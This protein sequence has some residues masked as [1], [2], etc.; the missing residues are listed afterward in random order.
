MADPTFAEAITIQTQ[1]EIRTESLATAASM[2]DVD[3]QGWDDH[4]PQRAIFEIDAFALSQEQKIRRA[5][6]YAGFISTAAIAGEDF[7]DQ[8]ITWFD[9][10]NGYGGKGRIPA[11]YAVWSLF[12]TDSANAGPFTIG[13]DTHELVAQANDGT[14]FQ[15]TNTSPVNIAKGGGALIEFT[16]MT[17]GSLAG[18]QNSGNI[19]HLVTSQ[20]GLNTIT[21]ASP[22]TLDEAARDIETT[23]AALVR[24]LGKWG[25]VGAG[26]TR[27]SFDYLIPTAA[28]TV[29]RWRVRD[30]NPN[31]PGTIE[32]IASNEGGASTSGENAAILAALG[33]PAVM[34]LGTGGLSV[35]SA[36]PLSVTVSGV[37]YGDGTNG[38]LLT[39]AKAALDVIRMKFPIGGDS[40]GYLRLDLLTTILMGGAFPASAPLVITDANG[41]KTVIILPGF[42]GAKHVVLTAPLVD[43]VVSTSEVV[44]FVYTGLVLG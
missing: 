36:T 11:T 31:G 4:S 17:I 8:A 32:V 9:I 15:S 44:T 42:K 34:T 23:S 38:S 39:N 22:A 19:T 14:L 24:A 5:L 2:F 10:D 40:D 27:T 25:T 16:C 37:L 1:A 21:N 29:T 12:V 33:A 3:V 18:N 41:Q 6:A 26:W 7:F 28:P 13:A 35:I 43:V 20:P 30:D